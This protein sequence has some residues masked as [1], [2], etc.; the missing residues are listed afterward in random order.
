VILIE[1]EATKEDGKQEANGRNHVCGGNVAVRS[2]DSHAH[3]RSY[4]ICEYEDEHKREQVEFT[5]LVE[6]NH[7]IRK[8]SK[9]EWWQYSHG[10]QVEKQHAH[11]V[12]VRPVHS[13]RS[14]TLEQETIF[15]PN[16]QR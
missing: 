1:K 5:A 10:Q 15:F 3:T 16:W 11:E 9:E 4:N 13:A 14:L 6:S 2:A 12:R 8:K 7:P